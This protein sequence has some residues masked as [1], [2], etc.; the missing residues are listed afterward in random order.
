M[1]GEF[2][3]DYVTKRAITP[4]FALLHGLD[5]TVPSPEV[6]NERFKFRSG[7]ALVAKLFADVKSLVCF[8]I[9]RKDGY[10]NYVARVNG[11]Y[12]NQEGE[13]LRF[14]YTK[15]GRRMP[16]IPGVVL[17]AA[18]DVTKPLIFAEGFF[19]AL[20]VLHAGALVIGFN[21]PWIN[22]AQTS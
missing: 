16:W 6:I 19:K 15:F 2:G 7:P 22:E 8:P 1:L 14:I 3:V 5:E 12:R 20:A 4:E 13:E 10:T 21:G 17:D 9:F 18:K 11:V